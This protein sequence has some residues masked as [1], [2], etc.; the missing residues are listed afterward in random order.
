ME[1]GI[2]LW[3]LDVLVGEGQGHEEGR[4]LRAAG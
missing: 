1:H 4:L 3:A 2:A